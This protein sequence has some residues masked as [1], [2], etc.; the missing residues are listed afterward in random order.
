MQ[1]LKNASATAPTDR[2]PV[3]VISAK[4]ELTWISPPDREVFKL[5]QDATLPLIV[6]EFNA[7]GE[8]PF[9]W[10]WS[11]EW[12]AKASGLRERARQGQVLRRFSQSG[13]FQSSS[14]RWIV[15]FGGEVLGGLLTVTVQ[16]GNESLARTVMIQGQNPSPEQVATY[17]ET[18]EDL[19]GFAALLEQETRTQHFINLDGEPV[20][21]F[22]QG[23]GITQLTHPAP[24]YEQAWN[25][26]ANIQGGSAVYQEK[27]RAARRY[28]SQAGRTYTDEQLLRETLSRWNGGA[29]HQ[30][31]AAASAWVRKPQILCDTLTGNIGWDTRNEENSDKTESQLRERDKDTYGQGRQGQ[32]AE[33]PWAYSGVCYADHL[34]DD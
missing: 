29:Y 10:S 2:A 9:T 14:K 5:E 19:T 30:W 27:A 34:L 8:G 4:R 18:L 20:V 33:H 15:D 22:D 3:R 11:I 21:A 25:W 17:I 1:T 26:K 24:S 6:F 13:T 32:S 12:E 23:Y 28:L 16:T 7:P 31:D